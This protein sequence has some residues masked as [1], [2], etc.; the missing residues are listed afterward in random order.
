V[1]EQAET[2]KMIAEE[3][4]G[5]DFD[6]KTRPEDRNELWKAR[7][8]AAFANLAYRPGCMAY[9]A[10]VCV[11]ISRLTD[12]IVETKKDIQESWLTAPMIGHVGDGNFHVSFLIMMDDPKE[13]AEAKRLN[14]R[15][16]S[17]AIQMDGTCSGEHGIGINKKPY[18]AE[19]HGDTV[20]VMR[21]IKKCIDPHNI[22][23][24]G[25]IFDL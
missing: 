7:H 1:K 24:P 5:S 3:N 4:G 13:L 18:M 8:E 19:E 17:R 11:P 25:K 12:C 23:N 22:M 16:V 14:A 20:D 9:T 10:D 15:L 6:W 21:M 2:F